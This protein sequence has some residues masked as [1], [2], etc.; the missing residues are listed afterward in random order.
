MS[1]V[2]RKCHCGI[3]FIAKLSDIKRG[4]AKSCSKSCATSLSNK[5]TGKYSKYLKTKEYNNEFGGKPEFDKYGTYIGFTS[6]FF[7]NEE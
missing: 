4:W 3:K 1:K 7:S 2:E 6:E 5:K